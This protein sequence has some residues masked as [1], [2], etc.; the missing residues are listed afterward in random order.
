MKYY[1]S[2]GFNAETIELLL[3][4]WRGSTKEQY[5]VYLKQWCAYFKNRGE[6]YAPTLRNGIKFLTFLFHTKGYTYNQIAMARSAL[7]SVI[8]MENH[9]GVTFGKHPLVKR[10]IK[11]VFESW[12]TFPRYTIVWNVNTLFTFFRHL[13]DQKWLSME[14]LGKKLALLI[15]I[16]GGGQR[17][18]TIHKINALDIKVVNNKCVIP[19]LDTIKQTKPGKHMNPMQFSVYLHD[20][21]LCVIDNLKEYLRKTSSYRKNPELFLSYHR[22]YAPVSKDT[23]ARWCKEVMHLAGIDV[24]KHSCHSS[25]AAASSYARSKGVSLRRICNSAGWSSEQTFARFYKK[26]VELEDFAMAILP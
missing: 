15:G 1:K 24:D 5:N 8:E 26:R 18:Q 4:S 25:R 9:C 13:G 12:P 10:L 22:P 19:I 2:K 7:S 23:I 3:R 6:P 14:M 21:T 20:P 17:S 11:G 16:L